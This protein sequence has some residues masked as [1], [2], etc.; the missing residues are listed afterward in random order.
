MLT[1]RVTILLVVI[2]ATCSAATVDNSARVRRVPVEWRAV[3][4]V[5]ADAETGKALFSPP[6][7]AVS[8]E[9]VAVATRQGTVRIHDPR[10]G[11]IQR[12][13]PAD[14]SRPAPITGVW[15]AAGT[16]IVSRG[17]PGVAEQS[18]SG[19]D[20]RTG[21]ALWRRAITV[22][23]RQPQAE[24]T[25]GYHGPQIMATERGIVVLER[26]DEPVDIQA[27]D[28]RTGTTTAQLTYPRGCRLTGAATARSVTLL[29][30]C[31]GNKL[32]LASLSPRT[33]R[34]EWTRQL[35]SSSSPE[36]GD[37][38]IR[39]TTNAEGYVHVSAGDDDFFCGPGGRLLS[40]GPQAVKVTDLNRWS[41]PL[42]VGSHPAADDHGGALLEST[43]PL[44]AYLISVDPGTGRLGGLPIDL[45]A[46]RVSLAGSSRYM[47]FVHSDVPG[48]GRLTAYRLI[49]GA[50]PPKIAWPPACDLL[51]TRDLAVF[52]DGYRAAPGADGAAKC[53][54][55]PSTD[56]GA[57]VSLS[58]EWVSS[59]DV[60]AR[61][62]FTAEVAAIEETGEVDPTTEAP[63]FL[64][65]TVARTN[66]FYGATIIN[67]GPVIV[68]LAS[69]SRQAVRLISPLLRDNLLARYQPGVPAPA[70]A[71]ESGW[72]FPTD[73]A[74][75][76]DPVVAGRAVY[77]AS[78]DGTVSAL[79]AVTGA[80]RWRF[81]TGD[82]VWYRHVV[83]DG[84]VYAAGSALVALDMATG[85][86]RWRRKI[87]L[88]G[89]PVAAAGR[90]YV[91]TRHPAWSGR[92]TLVTLDAA[93]GE[94][95]WTFQPE[96][97]VLDA[98]PVLAGEVVLTSSGQ[99]S[100]HALDPATGAVKWSHRA[101]AEHDHLRMVR[102]G[103]TVYAVSTDG[104]VHALDA[105]SGDLRWTSRVAGTVGSH[106]VVAGEVL[107]IGVSEGATYALDAATGKPLWTFQAKRDLPSYIWSAAVADGLLCLAGA[108]GRLYALDTTTGRVHWSLPLAKGHGAGARGRGAGPVAAH[109]TIHVTDHEGTLHALDA[110]TGT[111]RSKFRIGGT[112]A[113]NPVVGDRFV[114]VGSSNGNVY[115]RPTTG[116]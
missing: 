43:W 28:P 100:I 54:W 73:A 102:A 110:A 11:A 58:V 107:Y 59:S 90:L 65:Y 86:P 106:P 98:D 36:D 18:L 91:W 70:P 16:V 95:L 39:L 32:R 68:R 33:L 41:P 23:G 82:S 87:R 35:P 69:S 25:G 52:A 24:V 85:R 109:G 88:S 105:L 63:G 55:V 57:V 7:H 76:V 96:G 114:Y 19:H 48:E 12:T 67:V 84:I 29:S 99:G 26:S 14:P 77:A 27:L 46:H 2:L 47:A 3:W 92:A 31:Q 34:Y 20:L 53:D 101:G 6:G 115:A 103:P 62:L 45:P 42:Y 44:P 13:I 108:D 5:P 72:S 97:D 66:G 60:G 104:N 56:D 1:T 80:L 51:T 50:A 8:G 83:A 113:T 78:G 21:A 15:I 10:T 40:T 93:S 4:S 89:D 74:V 81:Q 111:V 79:D 9:A 61:R 37:V 38:A 116:N 112:A 22:A 94:K 49:Y 17:E 71:R 75:R 30:Y 64:S